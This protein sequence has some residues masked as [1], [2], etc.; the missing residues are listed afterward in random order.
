MSEFEMAN[1]RLNPD[2]DR[3]L[4]SVGDTLNKGRSAA[5]LAVNTA[6]RIMELK[7]L[8]GYPEI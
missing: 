7:F 3:L 1:P 4:Q 8:R 6:M 5:A 2:Y